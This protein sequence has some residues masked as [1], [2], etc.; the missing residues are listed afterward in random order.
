MNNTF[1][2][3]K[4]P[5]LFRSFESDVARL[6][7]IN[8]EEAETAVV[9][10]K[11]EY[12]QK[13]TYVRT[14]GAK[15]FFFLVAG[16][17]LFVVAIGASVYLYWTYTKTNTVQ[18]V[19]TREY[20]NF[21]ISR[22]KVVS[23]TSLLE[24]SLSQKQNGF[25]MISLV[26]AETPLS[27]SELYALLPTKKGEERNVDFQTFAYAYDKKGDTA[28]PFILLKEN[29]STA[30]IIPSIYDDLARSLGLYLLDLSDEAK[31]LL[32]DERFVQGFINNIPVRNLT[33]RTEEGEEGVVILRAPETGYVVITTKASLLSGLFDSLSQSP[34]V[35]SL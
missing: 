13:R 25:I 12:E 35:L 16:S 19:G 29:T 1:E 22:E 2:Q 21:E 3:P 11:R 18:E 27:L 4:K 34:I 5:T 33:V 7:N 26:N 30:P 32:E 15:R 10:K 17:I 23:I 9:Q 24:E 31:T 8:K 20:I 28:F 6:L 14:V